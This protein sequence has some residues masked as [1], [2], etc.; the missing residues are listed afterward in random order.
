MEAKEFV[1]A[2]SSETRRIQ[3][4]LLTVGYFAY[5]VKFHPTG[6]EYLP[7]LEIEARPGSESDRALL[8]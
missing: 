2:L 8:G 6:D 5:T 1:A 3:E 4:A 7:R